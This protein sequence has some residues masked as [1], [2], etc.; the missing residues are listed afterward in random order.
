[1][2]PH[3]PE[4]IVATPAPAS[5]L[6]SV[7]L[8]VIAITFQHSL[9]PRS[10]AAPPSCLIMTVQYAHGLSLTLRGNIISQRALRSLRHC[11]AEYSFD[12]SASDFGT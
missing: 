11:L 5:L 4:S 10:V 2:H 3:C 12:A 9:E 6:C 7:P 1:M 8:S